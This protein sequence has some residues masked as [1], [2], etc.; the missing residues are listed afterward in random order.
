LVVARPV[1]L[2]PV[3]ALVAIALVSS[4]LLAE[5]TGGRE[6]AN[7]APSLLD[8]GRRPFVLF[9]SYEATRLGPNWGSFPPL[10]PLFFGALVRPFAAVTDDFFAIR[11]AVLAWTALALI[12]LEQVVDRVERAPRER[13]RESLWTYALLPSVWGPIAFLPQEESYVSLFALALYAAART[14]RYWL[15][16]PLLVATALSAKYFLLVLVAPLAFATP[17]PW[18]R[19][20]GWSALVGGVLCAY[21][22]YHWL[23][24]GLVPILS[25]RVEPTM[26]ISVW[27]L[28]WHL[29]VQPPLPLVSLAGTVL[30]GGAALAFSAAARARGLPLAHAMAGSLWLALLFLSLTAPAYVLWVVP[31]TLVCMT[32]I[33]EARLRALLVVLLAA[34][35]AGEWTANLA[36][37]TAMAAGRGDAVGAIAARVVDLVGSGFPFAAV[38]VAAIAVVILSGA[39]L[40]ALLWRTGCEEARVQPLRAGVEQAARARAVPG[41]SV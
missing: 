23:R 15:V 26:S 41:G 37:G 7:D 32:G 27:G 1:W 12:A 28:L 30:A 40:T 29:A 24:F 31:L 11:L 36:R 2:L 19:L 34:W 16:A 10:L 8:L 22:G 35:A 20:V 3:A 38:H 21:L 4:A 5:V 14:G 13:V 25:H 39:L 17:R 6:F 33:R 18:R 9:S